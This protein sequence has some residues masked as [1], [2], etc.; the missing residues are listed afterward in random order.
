MA[1]VALQPLVSVTVTEK[2]PAHKLSAVFVVSPF[3]QR[4]VKGVAGLE[5]VAVAEP[6]HSPKQKTSLFF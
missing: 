2:V 3:D 1:F 5:A 6:S 4:Y